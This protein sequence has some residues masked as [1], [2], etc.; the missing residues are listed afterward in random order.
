LV[1]SFYLFP[2]SQLAVVLSDDDAL[3]HTDRDPDHDRDPDPDPDHDP[4]HDPD[5]DHD[6]DP[7]PDPDHDPDRLYFRR[8]TS[9]LRHE[10]FDGADLDVERALANALRVLESLVGQR[11]SLVYHAG[12]FQL[13]ARFVH[14]DKRTGV[15]VGITPDRNLLPE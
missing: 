1:A 6:R 5:P 13:D 10:R 8:I 14:A 2:W 9:H 3:G 4:D 7:D 15:D 11:T 12:V